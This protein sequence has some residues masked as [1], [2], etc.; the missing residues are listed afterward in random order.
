[1][2]RR[3]VIVAFVAGVVI[4]TAATGAATKMLITGGQIKDGSITARDLAPALRAQLGAAS[5]GG[6]TGARG[7]KGDKGD[8]GER[9]VQGEAGTPGATGRDGQ[10]IVAMTTASQAM[11]TAYTWTTVA[12]LTFSGSTTALN[13]I[14]TT[15]LSANA[16]PDPGVTWCVAHSRIVVDGGPNEAQGWD[17]WLSYT[18]GVHTVALQ[19]RYSDISVQP[20]PCT[21]QAAQVTVGPV[22]VWVETAL[23]PS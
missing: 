9:G 8:A 16:L 1:M 22:Q 5:S 17:A 21:N 11:T 12:S 3:E 19:V 13:R 10:A 23:P 18:P 4:A 2:V 6:A 15:W 14:Q 20:G 7:Q